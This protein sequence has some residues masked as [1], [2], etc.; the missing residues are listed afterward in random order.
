MPAS[1]PASTFS[2][3]DEG[4]P[5]SEAV[6]ST[7]PGSVKTWVDSLVRRGFVGRPEVFSLDREFGRGGSLQAGAVQEGGGQSTVNFQ[8]GSLRSSFKI[9]LIHGLQPQCR[10]HQLRLSRPWEARA[11][12]KAILAPLIEE[13]GQ[14]DVCEDDLSD[15]ALGTMENE[16]RARRRL[17]LT[18][19][20][21]LN[22]DWHRDVRGAECFVR[23]L[24]SRVGSVLQGTELP[25][26]I[27]RQRW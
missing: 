5:A 21:G 22:R 13:R 12:V 7:Q 16:V 19:N 26:A 11:V 15:T 10:R 1:G 25:R 3:L 4:I 18:W 8:T 17:R 6:P 2:V 27:R 20:S 14:S 24:A 9:S 23:E